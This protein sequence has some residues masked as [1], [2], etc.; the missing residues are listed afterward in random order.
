MNICIDIETIPSTDP[1]VIEVFHANARENF[2]VPSGLTKEQAAADLGFTDKD[3]IKCINKDTMLAT[4][5]EHFRDTKC[6]EQAEEQWLKTSFD[7]A[8][9][10]IA[11]IGLAFDDADPIALY[12]DDW[13]HDEAKILRLAFEAIA[14]S[15]NPTS[16]RRPL[17]IGHYVADFDLRF[18]FQRAVILG[19]KPPMF[20]PFHAK[21]W[22]EHIY[23]TMMAWAGHKG[24]IKLGKLCEALGLPGKDGLD[25]SMVWPMV[26]DGKIKEV[27]DYC[28][29]DVWMA[30]AAY[31]R[32]TF[33]NAEAA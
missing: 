28:A 5:V 8:L 6:G 25:G 2:K 12:S 13:K 26:R 10:Q 23:D 32:M 19:I 27:G 29:H 1:A 20:I 9:G 11:V 15:Y 24:T 31:Q 4:W 22:S 7:G 16:Q 14:D 3:Q 21:A 33:A 18:L 30:R 17:F